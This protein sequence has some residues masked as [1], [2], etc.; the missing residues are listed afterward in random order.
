MQEDIHIGKLIKKQIHEEG[1]SITWFARKLSYERRNI[2]NLFEKPSLNSHLLLRI[3]KIL[4]HNFFE[5]Y[6][7]YLKD[8]LSNN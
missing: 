4:K 6:Y 3:S 8:H 7:K 5:H 2:Y 1:R